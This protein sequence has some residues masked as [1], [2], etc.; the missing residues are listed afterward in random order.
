MRVV[1]RGSL[2]RGSFRVRDG[3]LEVVR[4]E[5]P[6]QDGT[7]DR[8]PSARHGEEQRF[9]RLQVQGAQGSLQ[10]GLPFL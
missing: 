10:D 6:S 3:L 8:G 5:L 7:D 9:R 1:R 4:A 2:F